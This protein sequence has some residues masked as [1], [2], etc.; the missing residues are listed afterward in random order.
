ML[1]P[2]LLPSALCYST[3]STFTPG[4]FMIKR[5]IGQLGFATETE[6]AYNKD[7]V[8]VAPNPLD[9]SQPKRTIDASGVSVRLFDAKLCVKRILTRAPS[10]CLSLDPCVHCHYSPLRGARSS[11]VLAA[12]M[13]G[14]CC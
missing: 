9:P 3:L 11:P 8:P 2:I 4:A 6:W 5:Q 14:V 13:V 7:G 12:M 10:R 1:L